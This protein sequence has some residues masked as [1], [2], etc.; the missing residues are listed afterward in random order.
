[1][2]AKKMT[3]K[4]IQAQLGYK[5]EIVDEKENLLGDVPVGGV[6]KLSDRNEKFDVIVLER[7]DD[8]TSVVLKTPYKRGIFDTQSSDYSK[9]YIRRELNSNFYNS[10]RSVIGCGKLVKHKVDLTGDDGRNKF[11]FCEDLISLMTAP[12]ARKYV[13]ILDKVSLPFSYMCWTATAKSPKSYSNGHKYVCTV[14]GGIANNGCWHEYWYRP[15]FV[16]KNDTTV[17]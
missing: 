13:N 16:L 3:I 8:T 15:F 4:E 1:M 10:L 17:Y 2:A 12:M 6:A 14:N 5:I 7:N 11:G 9:S